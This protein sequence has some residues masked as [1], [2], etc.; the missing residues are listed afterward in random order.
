MYTIKSYMGKKFRQ[1]YGYPS[2]KENYVL[3]KSIARCISP[4][5]DF[6]K[7]GN[8]L[9]QWYQYDNLPFNNYYLYG[10]LDSINIDNKN[11]SLQSCNL[12][13][14]YDDMISKID[15]LKLGFYNTFITINEDIVLEPESYIRRLWTN[16]DN[17]DRNGNPAGSNI[18]MAY[19]ILNDY[20]IEEFYSVDILNNIRILINVEFAPSNKNPYLP[21]IRFGITVVGFQSKFFDNYF[22]LGCF[23]HKANLLRKLINRYTGY[24]DP[25]AND[26]VV[27]KKIDMRPINHS[28]NDDKRRKKVSYNGLGRD[29]TYLTPAE[30]EEYLREQQRKNI[31]YKKS[32]TTYTSDSKNMTYADANGIGGDPYKYVKNA[33]YNHDDNLRLIPYGYYRKNPTEYYLNIPYESYELHDTLYSIVHN[34][35]LYRD[36]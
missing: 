7:L 26:Y 25:N 2:Y 14:I 16:G 11:T 36:C 24:Y 9:Y 31:V 17:C 29:I 15:N 21:D 12:K 20:L 30:R 22:S 27:S 3:E 18:T 19:N 1:E 4:Y 23:T 33:I 35:V 10:K 28:I 8:G 13:Y 6:N 32:S 5:F 34:N